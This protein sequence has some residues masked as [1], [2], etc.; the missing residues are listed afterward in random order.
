MCTVP[1]PSTI[2]RSHAPGV[3]V[4]A[5]PPHVHRLAAV[6]HGRHRP[7]PRREPRPPP[8]WR[9]RPAS[10]RPRLAKKFAHGVQLRPSGHGH[11]DRRGPKPAGHPL[12]AVAP[13]SAPAAAGCRCGRWPRR[14][15]SRRRR[16]GRRRRGRGRRRWRAAAGSRWRCRGSRRSTCRS[17]A[18]CRDAQPQ[19][20]AFQAGRRRRRPDGRR[21]RRGPAGARRSQSTTSTP[22]PGR[23]ATS[24]ITPYTTAVATPWAAPSPAGAERPRRHALARPPPGDVR[25]ARPWPA[26]RAA[27]A[28]ASAPVEALAPAVRAAIRKVAA[29]PATTTEEASA[30]PGQVRRASRPPRRSAAAARRARAHSDAAAASSAG[31]RGR[32]PAPSPRRPSR[33]PARRHAPGTGGPRRTARATISC[34]SC[35]AERSHAT[36]RMPRP[37]VADL[38][39]VPYAA[40]HVT[41]NPA[42]QDRVEELRTVVGGDRGA[43]RHADPHS[44]E[45]PGST[46]RRST[47]WSAPRWLRS[48][49]V[50]A[51]R[52]SRPPRGTGRCPPARPGP[53]GSRRL[54]AGAPPSTRSGS[55]ASVLPGSSRVLHLATPPPALPAG[56]WALLEGSTDP[57]LARFIGAARDHR[58]SAS[59]SRWCTVTRSR[60]AV[61]SARRRRR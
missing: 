56:R 32:G 43:Q 18:G 19:A 39:T 30:V 11:L 50:T 21:P 29:W 48:Q 6:D 8:S 49:P 37:A 40:V 58:G 54:R 44:R 23:L 12:L 52:S 34:T 25:A 61:A 9:S 10:R 20:G 38:T 15:G 46:A 45:R 2:S 24:T 1:P 7:E 5:Q 33:A 60:P 16:R 26:A 31:R 27:P 41:E 14:P 42:G 47:P 53:R 55:S 22:A 35:P 51:R 36:A 28:A 57:R 13:A 17:S 4:L 59:R 3:E